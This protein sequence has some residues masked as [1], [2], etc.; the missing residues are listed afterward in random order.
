MIRALDIGAEQWRLNDSAFLA[1]D[2]SVG[3]T[4]QRQSAGKA[5]FGGT[6]GFFVITTQGSGTMLV[7]AYGDILEIPLDGTRPF[8]VDNTHV[9]AWSQSLNYNISV[10]SGTFGFKTGE[11]LVNEFYGQGR[12]LVQTRNIQSLAALIS[13]HIAKG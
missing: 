9:V 8:V 4:M 12:V 6:G 11:G 1:C 10:A 3:Y 7:N 5:I 13:Q 2:A